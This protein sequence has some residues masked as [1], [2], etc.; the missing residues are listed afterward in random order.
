MDEADAEDAARETGQP[1]TRDGPTLTRLTKQGAKTSTAVAADVP[2]K[3]DLPTKPVSTQKE[4]A[5][6][7]AENPD[8]VGPD[9]SEAMDSSQE[10]AGLI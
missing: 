6:A 3:R 7:V 1:A 5:G 8:N 10:A 4:A 9:S 2:V